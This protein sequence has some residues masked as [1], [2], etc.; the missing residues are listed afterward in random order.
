VFLSSPYRE[1]QKRNKKIGTG[2]KFRRTTPQNIFYHVFEFPLPRGAE[3]TQQKSRKKKKS[4]KS[5]R[6]KSSS[7]KNISPVIFF[8][9]YFSRVFE[10]PLPRNAQKR[11]KKKKEGTHVLF[12][13]AGADARRFPVFLFFCRPL[14]TTARA[15]NFAAKTECLI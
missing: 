9:N 8:D 4:K 2:K 6:K 7:R 15:S 1:T 14:P 13:R 3:P 11:T 10:L 5:T 12:L